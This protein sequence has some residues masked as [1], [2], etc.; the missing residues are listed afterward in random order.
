MKILFIHNTYQQSGG[1]DVAVQ[2]EIKL[3]RQKGHIAEAVYFDNSGIQSAY[4]KIKAGL[5]AVYNQ[6]SFSIINNKIKDFGPDLIHLHNL[7]FTA[8]PSV[9]YAAAKHHIPVVATIHNYR[10]VCANALLMRNHSPCELCI[11]KTFPLAGIIHGCYR[12]SVIESALVTTTTG[13]HKLAGT[14]RKK[15]NQYIA[16]TPFAKE[17]LLHSSLQIPTG[18]ITVKPNFVPDYGEGNT[19]REDFF[20]F[21]GRLSFEKGA[22]IMLQSFSQLPHIK[23]V[24]AGD[25]PEKERLATKFGSSTNITFVGKKP[26]EEIISL[27]QRC[28]ALIFPSIWYEGQPYTIL[29]A[30]ATGTPVIASKLGAMESLIKHELNGLHF[31]P[32]NSNELCCAVRA[33]NSLTDSGAYY[34]NARK[35]YLENHHPDVHYAEIMKIYTDAIT[36][37]Q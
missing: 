37:K 1:E 8:S 4:S 3:L 33:F 34:N 29:E 20:L 9:L 30:F 7:F 26:A 27:M 21:A 36:N 25:G 11:N 24:V 35:T 22:E 15:I 5:R 6:G 10:L 32:G 23:L 12:S 28:K 17:K 16:L 13:L 31:T 2:E 18:K 14:W 19:I